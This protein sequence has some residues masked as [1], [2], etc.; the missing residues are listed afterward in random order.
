MIRTHFGFCFTQHADIKQKKYILY[1]VVLLGNL[2]LSFGHRFFFFFFPLVCACRFSSSSDPPSAMW[3]LSK[4]HKKH[5][6]PS[7][8][9]TAY[10]SK[11]LKHDTR[12]PEAPAVSPA[13]KRFIQGLLEADPAARL[14]SRRGAAEVQRHPFFSGVRWALLADARHP[15]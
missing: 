4:F 5:C 7:R 12:F 13:A 3:V 6:S 11:T 14:G 9:A 8:P 10:E 1:L 15:P 2:F